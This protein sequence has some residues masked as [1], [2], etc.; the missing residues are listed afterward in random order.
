M[1]LRRVSSALITVGLIS[2]ATAACAQVP[3]PVQNINPHHHP[4]LA[5]AQQHIGEAY[6]FISAA[7]RANQNQL[8]GHADRAKQLLDQASA[9][10]KAAALTANAE[11]R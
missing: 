11:G 5:A 2:V 6:N 8:G 10:L 1:N 7:Q 4:N 9:E 3:P